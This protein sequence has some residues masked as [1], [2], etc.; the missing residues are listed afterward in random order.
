[1]VICPHCDSQIS[2]IRMNPLN[3]VAPNLT[4]W[5]C[6]AYCCPSCSKAISVDVDLTAVRADII[7]AIERLRQR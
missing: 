5:S 7:A 6:V 3:G 2:T 4:Q 1:M